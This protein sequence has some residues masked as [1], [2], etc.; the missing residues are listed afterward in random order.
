[1]SARLSKAASTA[2]RRPSSDRVS[3]PALLAAKRLLQEA[4][5]L[6]AARQTL[7]AL[8]QVL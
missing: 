6:E 7:A 5:S 8:G 3:L 2:R 4:G 1:M